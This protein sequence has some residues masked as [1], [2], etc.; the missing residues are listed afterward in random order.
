MY[1]VIFLLHIPVKRWQHLG[2]VQISSEPSRRAVPH[3]SEFC[4]FS[5]EADGLSKHVVL[6]ENMEEEVV[7]IGFVW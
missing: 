4:V 2:S 1:H 6:F 7:T 5:V 3:A